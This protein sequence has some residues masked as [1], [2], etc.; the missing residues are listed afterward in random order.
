MVTDL[1]ILEFSFPKIPKI[2]LRNYTRYIRAH[3]VVN[4]KKIE[5]DFHFVADKLEEWKKE[6]G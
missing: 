2:K 4:N 1:Q 5:E 3:K 6:N